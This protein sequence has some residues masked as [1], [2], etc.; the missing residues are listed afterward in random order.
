MCEMSRLS[1]FG[2]VLL[3]QFLHLMEH[4]MVAIR[5]VSFCGMAC[6]NEETH[7]FFNAVIFVASIALV[8]SFPRN[9]WLVP[10]AILTTLH[11]A[12]HVYIYAQ[13]LQTHIAQ[14]PGLIGLGG[15][16]SDRKSTRLNS[17]HVEISYAVF[18]L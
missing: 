14:G 15:A 9:P 4:I 12:E 3:A 10:L 13:Y 5:G 8:I 2:A 17:S 16:T 1:I 11:L 6:D 18:C 7:L